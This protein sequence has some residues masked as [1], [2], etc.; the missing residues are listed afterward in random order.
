M[1]SFLIHD[2]SE[3]AINIDMIDAIEGF[4]G[5]THVLVGGEWIT[6][7]VPF[8]DFMKGLER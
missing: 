6:F 3:R 2:E 1:T 8:A 5:T 4:V 7:P